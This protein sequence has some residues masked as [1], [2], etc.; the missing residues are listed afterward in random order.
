V[1]GTYLAVI[2]A[3][4]PARHVALVGARALQGTGDTRTPMYVNVASNLLNIAGS[5]GFGLGVGPFLE[6]RVVGVGLATAFGNVFTAVAFVAAIRWDL[7]HASFTRPRDL[8]IARQLLSV[9]APRVAEGLV[10]TAV[11]FPFNS[12]LLTFGTDVNAAYQ[13][14]RRMYQQVTSPL[15]RGVNDG[16]SVLVGQAL[17][18]GDDG[19]AGDRG[20]G[21]T[22]PRARR[23]AGTFGV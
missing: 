21:V 6:W 20:G 15:S 13:I 7:T 16:A 22:R 19:G 17:G 3:T 5:V 18:D 8:T 1:G 12:L 11:E 9:S 14:G 23:L 4:A 10:A 2:F